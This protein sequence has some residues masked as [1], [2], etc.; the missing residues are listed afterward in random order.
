[1]GISGLSG[2]FVRAHKKILLEALE[3]YCAN[4]ADKKAWPEAVRKDPDLANLDSLKGQIESC[5]ESA[6]NQMVLTGDAFRLLTTVTA[7]FRNHLTKRMNESK[8]WTNK[9]RIRAQLDELNKRE[10]REDMFGER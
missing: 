3:S 4:I 5:N 6:E 9:E 10:F 7:E 1:M 2:A 8:P